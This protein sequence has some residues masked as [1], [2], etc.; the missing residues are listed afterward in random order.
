MVTADG[1]PGKKF[2]GKVTMVIPRM[3]RRALQTDEPG[4]YKD[5]YF[6]E[7]MIDM[8]EGAELPLNLRVQVRIHPAPAERPQ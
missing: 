8:E 6:R 4:E 7:A 2:H 5:L 1:F 3:G